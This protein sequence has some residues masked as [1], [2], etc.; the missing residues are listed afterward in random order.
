[1]KVLVVHN[2]YRIAG[3]EDVVVSA[4]LDLLR[5]NGH[6]VE[7]LARSN[8]EIDDIGRVRASIE[9]IWSRRSAAE[10]RRI[11][12]RFR[13]DVV[14]VHNSFPLLSAS[15]YSSAASLGL[16]V[17]KT[18]HNFRLLCIQGNLLRDGKPCHDCLDGMPI[19]GAIHACYR[20]SLPQSLVATA[21][22]NSQR[23]LG[24]Y[25]KR[26]DRFIVMSR[27]AE[28]LFSAG[29]LPAER[30]QVKPNFT[31][32]VPDRG[33][34]RSGFLFVGRLSVEK[35]V[36]VLAR[37]VEPAN[38]AQTVLVAG[39]GPLSGLLE[40]S[41]GLRLLGRVDSSEVSSLMQSREALVVPSTCYEGC[42]MV[43]LEAYS[44]G[45]P[46]IASRLGSLP[47]YVEDGVTGLLFEPGD[48]DDLARK[49][50]W[51]ADHPAEMRVMGAAARARH[52]ER[53]T[54]ETNYRQL[55]HAYEQAMAAS[56]RD[57]A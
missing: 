34:H 9:S 25:R 54:P 16:P 2:S 26:V 5:R 32:V 29:G 17:V 12:R 56:R 39:D 6:E 55:I 50:K 10:L 51:A 30:L 48:A 49:M 23:T 37:A 1:M 21:A 15:I 33:T 43:I 24:T 22:Q 41:R 40:G 53:F 3:G 46:V 13:P 31:S 7:L 52:R 8:C 36:S 44:N 18:L 47:E 35:G 27:F 57:S 14:H 28:R 11:A 20:K 4:E 19:W 38:P 42:P 45:L